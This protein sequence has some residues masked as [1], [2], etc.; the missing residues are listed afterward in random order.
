MRKIKKKTIL[1]LFI[2]VGLFVLGF[3]ALRFSP[4]NDHFSFEGIV[5]MV[6]EARLNPLSKVGFYVFFVIGVLFLP[7]TI[8]PV[9]GGV[10]F[11]FWI[12]L[13]MNVLAAT[14]GAW[15]AFGI[16]RFF[17]RDAMEAFLKGRFKSYDR[18]TASRGVRAVALLRWLGVPPFAV[19]N[20]ILGLSAIKS[21]DYFVGTMIGIL[22]WM[23]MVTYASHSL[24][25]AILEG[26]KAGLGQA[27][28][29]SFGPIMILSATIV[30]TV[31]VTY[32]IKG[33]RSRRTGKATPGDYSNL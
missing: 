21:F 12:A 28:W 32:L 18:L 23:G 9:I 13:P 1:K 5:G 15:L 30:T 31:I 7:I 10:L 11:D 6:E 24:W 33:V 19:T 4:L 29:K 26:G 20:Y 16:S 14:L 3:V 27:L 25:Q 22:P 8:F 2:G 17:G